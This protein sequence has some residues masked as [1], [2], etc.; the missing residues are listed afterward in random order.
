MFRHFLLILLS[1]AAGF[2]LSQWTGPAPA[3]TNVKS[4]RST[5]SAKQ[6]P[7]L[8]Q[9][10]PLAE[11]MEKALAEGGWEENAK[12]WAQEDPAG[13]HAWLLQQDPAPP[14]ELSCLLFE[15][16]VLDAPDAAFAAAVNMPGRFQREKFIPKMLNGLLA[17]GTHD[18]TAIHWINRTADDFSGF[19]W[20][21]PA[22]FETKSPEAAAAMLSKVTATLYG[23]ALCRTTGGAMGREG[24]G[25]RAPM[26]GGVAS[27]TAEWCI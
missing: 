13:F 11:G 9:P 24:S 26:D 6:N 2:A 18:E 17:A 21:T 19:R 7:A 23:G 25:R 15:T 5:F 14:L 10:H 20:P 12:K 16:W 1:L 27:G 4:G 22:F 8:R 3:E